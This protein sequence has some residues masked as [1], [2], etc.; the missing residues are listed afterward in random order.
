MASDTRSSAPQAEGA[1]SPAPQI[2]RSGGLLERMLEDLPGPDEA[3][4]QAVDERASQVL[5]PAGAFGRLDQVAEWLAGWQ[6]TPAPAVERPAV[7][8]F[9][10]DHGVAAEGVSA[11]PA[12]VTAAMVSAIEGEVA[13]VTA[14]ARQVGAVVRCHVVGVGVPTGNIRT[15]DAMSADEF[16]AAVEAGAHAVE[17]AVESDGA[18]LLVLG[19]LGIGNTTAAA[20]ICG[21]LFGEGASGV[22]AHGPDR[23]ATSALARSSHDS[24]MSA[25]Q[26]AASLW[27]GPGTGVHGGALERK[28]AVVADA[29]ERVG[30]VSPA[31]ALR[32]LGGRELAALAGAALAARHRSIPVILDGF[33]GTAAVAP[34]ALAAPGSLDHCIA[35]HC[36]AEPG[37]RE[38]LSR[39]G[40]EPLVHLDLRL[41]EGTGALIAVPLVRIAAAAVTDVA[42]F[43]EWD[44]A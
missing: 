3:A 38:L 2:S 23:C 37:H 36:S 14:V 18:D 43:A 12:S 29:L 27:T 10:A 40:L 35:G 16:D 8:V 4:R 28:T 9:A 13:T 7:L 39:L 24:L 20:A 41:G 6:R 21:A 30:R 17:S 33:I 32:R 11:Y 1:R 22:D 26:A 5:R 31:E 42:T 19:E 15:H 34:L 44:L 25:A